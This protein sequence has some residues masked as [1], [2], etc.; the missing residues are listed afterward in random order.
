MFK[1]LFT[2][3]F[4]FTLLLQANSTPANEDIIINDEMFINDE[5]DI[6]YDKCIVECEDKNGEDDKCY[7]KCEELYEECLLKK[8]KE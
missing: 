3:C 4:V 1:Y 5:C 6:V 7:S 8:E 2:A